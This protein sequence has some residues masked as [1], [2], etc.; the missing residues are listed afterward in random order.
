MEETTVNLMLDATKSAK[1]VYHSLM[2]T[3][4]MDDTEFLSSEQLANKHIQCV[5]QA[6]E[7]FQIHCGKNQLIEDAAKAKLL[8][9]LD[10]AQHKFEMLNNLKSN[11]INRLAVAEARVIYIQRVADC[12][13]LSKNQYQL[14]HERCEEIASGEFKR[15]A[16]RGAKNY[17]YEKNVLKFI[18][19]CQ[20]S[21]NAS[22]Q[23]EKEVNF[24]LALALA[25]RRY[26]ELMEADCRRAEPCLSTKELKSE[27]EKNMKKSLEVFRK[28]FQSTVNESLKYENLCREEIDVE[29]NDFEIS[30]EGKGDANSLIAIILAK[31]ACDQHLKKSSEGNESHLSYADLRDLCRKCEHSAF[32]QLQENFTP[33]LSSE[34]KKK[35]SEQLNKYI[36][37]KCDTFARIN[38]ENATA[39]ASEYAFAARRMY[40]ESM[41][42]ALD[43]TDVPYL[44]TVELEEEH[45]RHEEISIRHLRSHVM[46]EGF[47]RWAM[48]E[49]KDSISY[50]YESC[51]LRNKIAAIKT[52]RPP[53][54]NAL[55]MYHQ[56][57]L[58]TYRRGPAGSFDPV[59][60]NRRCKEEA[61][62]QYRSS[63]NKNDKFF[64]TYET[65]LIE[66]I[67]TSYHR[68]LSNGN[69]LN[70]L[71]FQWTTALL[72]K[73]YL[74]FE[75]KNFKNYECNHGER[76]RAAHSKFLLLN[77]KNNRWIEFKEAIVEDLYWFENLDY[78]KNRFEN[79]GYDVIDGI[80]RDFLDLNFQVIVHKLEMKAINTL[81]SYF[82]DGASYVSYYELSS[83]EKL[84][85]R[86]FIV[87]CIIFVTLP[88]AGF[89]PVITVLITAIIVFLMLWVTLQKKIPTFLNSFQCL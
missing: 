50:F 18:S 38:R 28:K 78:L 20:E 77:S 25:K 21:I 59:T 52:C 15:I 13:K 10:A 72:K 83:N 14:K 41:E 69:M 89:P 46:E 65:K 9:Y 44:S 71:I 36:E 49:L 76:L 4:V 16:S 19:S 11:A 33:G 53:Y 61:L 17:E 63:I 84:E 79:I 81:N 22:K 7:I 75:S 80:K 5:E 85:R 27:H 47:S 32:E 6:L 24:L 60:E 2:T 66:D 68:L 37:Y 48:I 23:I 73:S 31:D 82:H 8:Q 67:D 54:L 64:Q 55:V 56:H 26:N 74:E 1:E 62:E 35:R 29:Y 34:F 51:K 45:R 39:T 12:G 43:R 57:M 40:R 70:I 86:L 88:V 30:N 42:N 87:A 58:E 3:V